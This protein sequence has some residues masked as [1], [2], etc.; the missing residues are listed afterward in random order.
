MLAAAIRIDRAVEADVGRGI[1]GDDAP[2]RN[3][4]HF[5]RERLELAERLPAIIHRLIGDGLVAA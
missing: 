4:L 1:A 5:G 2:S 3:L